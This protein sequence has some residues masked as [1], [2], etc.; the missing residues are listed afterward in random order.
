MRPPRIAWI[1]FLSI[2]A[3]PVFAQSYIWTGEL[4]TGWQGQLTPPNNGTANL[5]FGDSLYPQL[6]LTTSIDNVN[7][8]VLE[9]GNSI[10]FLSA[11]P[12]TLTLVSGIGSGDEV[13]G[14][15]DFGSNINLGISGSEI[16]NAGE[17]Y[18]YVRGQITGTG[19]LT[20]VGGPSGNDSFVFSNSG[21]GNTYTGNTFI[22]NGTSLVEV[23]FWNSSPFG[24]G[25]VTFLNGGSL[26]AH[27]TQTINNPLMI[28]SSGST[29]GLFLR[30]WDAPL[31][32]TGPVTL[33][34]NAFFDPRSS[35]SFLAAP[36]GDG[37]IV[38][39]GAL[40]RN[41]IVFSGNISESG[42]MHSITVQGQGVLMLT[43][44]SNTYTG[45]TIL[46]GASPF[47]SVVFGA[48]SIPASGTIS[49]P[50]GAYV[51]TADPSGGS[52]ASLMSHVTPGA[53]GSFGIDTLPGNPTINYA[54]AINLFGLGL[55]STVEI[56]T[57][58]SAI[59]SGSITPQT[60][61]TY[62]FGGG[63]GTLYVTTPIANSNL[64][65]S[66]N[67]SPNPLTLYLQGNNVSIGHAASSGGILIFDGANAL[68]GGTILKAA[69][70]AN[71]VGSSYVGYT[72]NVAITPAAFLAMFTPANTWGIIGFDSKVPATPVIIS[73]NIDLTGFNDGTFIGT[74]TNATLTGALTPSTVTNG[75]QAPNTLRLTAVNAGILTVNSVIAD[76]GPPVSVLLGTIGG[77]SIFG[78]GTVVMN[79]SNT[80]TGGTTING[81]NFEGLTLALGTNSALGTG[82]LTIANGLGG[83]ITGIQAAAGVNLPNNIVIQN[84]GGTG[85][86]QVSFTGTNNFTLSG[87][88]S[89]DHTS[90]LGL[91]N[92]VPIAVTLAGNNSGYAGT[93][94]VYNGTLKL[95]TSMSAGSGLASL[96]LEGSAATIDFTG[97]TSPFVESLHGALGNLVLGAGTVLTVDSTPL[98][99][100][101]SD[102]G[103]VISGAGSL[104]ITNTTAMNSHVTLLYGSNTY[105]GGT[106]VNQNGLLVLANNQGAGTGTVT[107]ATSSS[108]AFALDTGVTFTNSLVFTSGNLAG[109]GTFNPLD[110]GLAGTVT[111]GPSQGVAGGFPTSGNKNVAGT[112]S[113]AG[114]MIFDTGG[115]YYWTLQDN[116][117]ADGV[118]QLD[119]AG[120]LVINA[121][122][123][124]FGIDLLSYDS[125][126]T[127]NNAANFNVNAP[128]SWVI[129]TTGGTIL[130]FSASDFTLGVTGF[131]NGSIP[132]SQFSLTV[133]GADDQLSLNF[134]P[135][136][137]PS[138]YVLLV[139]G[140][141]L[142]TF[143]ASRR[144]RARA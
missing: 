131:E 53:G 137:E 37:S 20:L 17:N 75:S 41:P 91:Y 31:T 65:V 16:F 18:I 21:T 76:N 69:G 11:S 58:T 126:G 107:V 139:V 134:T 143:A 3:T 29:L 97:A 47:G 7:S 117:R 120:N 118:S 23:A 78:S 50:L 73:G 72:D 123:G 19:N 114:N 129:A 28:D 12:L 144:R 105:A 84:T 136:P 79:A 95:T 102:F 54:G 119:I 4:P 99:S 81:G 116:A 10:K 38:E 44:T 1:G 80:Y 6:T 48:G 70:T 26:V 124:G 89:G 77:P 61:G 86:S 63:G 87:S 103:G 122:A 138:T 57:A 88:I 30:S 14:S 130:N 33:D 15:M 85:A 74:S 9:G 5:Y 141:G 8:L 35:P 34:N 92:A 39:P 115:S 106:T 96:D 110:A 100:N 93:F 127:P 25:T 101:E 140:L 45:G 111:I 27:G 52:F 43:G 142:V 59:L 98:T 67:S 24:T 133:N 46:S 82:A 121:T 66:S 108:G 13:S 51:G 128:Y 60:A 68:P 22:G 112:L 83:G 104:T 42:G 36:S 55:A 32:F 49:V 132:L 71:N 113:F 125:T 94:Q 56:G 64:I 62:Q 109:Y 90:N 2:L 135:V 40:S